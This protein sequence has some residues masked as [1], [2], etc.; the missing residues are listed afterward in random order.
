MTSGQ[1]KED[2]RGMVGG[3]VWIELLPEKAIWAAPPRSK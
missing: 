3:I 1:P 2:Q